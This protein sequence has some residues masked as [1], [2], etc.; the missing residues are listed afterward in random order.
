MPGKLQNGSGSGSG[1]LFFKVKGAKH[2]LI[3]RRI[4]GRRA[5]GRNRGTELVVG[6][7]GQTLAGRRRRLGKATIQELKILKRVD[8]ASTALMS[9]LRTNE[10]IQTATLTLRK[11]GKGQLEYFKI[12]IEQGRV[13]ALNIE[14]DPASS[15]GELIETSASRSTRSSRVHAARQDGQPKGSTM[16]TDQWDAGS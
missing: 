16:F 15:N 3:N 8:I 13:T 1:D 14:V 2:G 9:A 4:A 11:A 5:Q 10:L 7:A 6:H 12:T